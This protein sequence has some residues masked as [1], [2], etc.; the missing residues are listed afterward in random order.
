MA[1]A[2]VFLVFGLRWA[3]QILYIKHLWIGEDDSMWPTTIA[4]FVTILNYTGIG[5]I[6]L[7]FF[8]AM[9]GTRK[10]DLYKFNSERNPLASAQILRYRVAEAGLAVGEICQAVCVG[11]S[12]LA[13]SEVLADLT[14]E[15][16]RESDAGLYGGIAAAYAVGVALFFYATNGFF[17]K[18]C[19]TYNFDMTSDEDGTNDNHTNGDDNE[20]T[21][22][23]SALETEC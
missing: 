4:R 2:V 19:Q 9:V 13:C 5:C 3:N 15:Q 14:K 21:G 23:G 1:A 8:Y 10:L 17:I 6:A 11:T 18:W 22:I 7:S 16:M 12:L 20:S